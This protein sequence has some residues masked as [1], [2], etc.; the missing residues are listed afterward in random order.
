MPEYQFRRLSDG[1]LVS[2]FYSM[3]DMPSI[4]DVVDIDGEPCK[5]I[6]SKGIQLHEDIKNVVHKYPYESHSIEPGWPGTYTGPTG[7]Q[8]IR[9]RQHEREIIRA[10][11]DAPGK[12]Y[13]RI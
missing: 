11:Q 6:A 5:R 2:R 10:S 1:E 8:V 12:P 7:G 3:H 9:S 13:T 4:G